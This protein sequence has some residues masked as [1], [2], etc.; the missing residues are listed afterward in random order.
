MGSPRLP[1]YMYDH[2]TIYNM[3]VSI[4]VWPFYYLYDYV[5]C[6][7]TCMAIYVFTCTIRL[8][9][10]L[11]IHKTIYT[12]GLS[13]WLSVWLFIPWGFLYDYLYDY[14]YHVA[15]YIAYLFGYM[16]ICMTISIIRLF[17]WPYD[18]PYDYFY[19]RGTSM[20]W[21]SICLS[22]LYMAIWLFA[23]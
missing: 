8:S 10:C 21:L 4:I 17:V 15:F 13:I 12:I 7:V 19:H 1:T 23:S 3:T 20:V 9:L 11:A 5:P 18:Y 16:I 2:M 22:I 14:L 6:R